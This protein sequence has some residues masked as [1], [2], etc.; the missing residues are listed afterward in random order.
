MPPSKHETQFDSRSRST[1]PYPSERSAAKQSQRTANALPTSHACTHRHPNQPATGRAGWTKL[2]CCTAL[3]CT[4]P[5]A[6]PPAVVE[7]DAPGAGDD[8]YHF[9]CA[10]GGQLVR[11]PRFTGAVGAVLCCAVRSRTQ[12]AQVGERQWLG[13]M[14]ECC[15]STHCELCVCCCTG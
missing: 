3:R 10:R 9:S 11:R 8:T 2:L 12:A 5:P 6:R 13:S 1:F 4:L 14:V 15:R 7:L